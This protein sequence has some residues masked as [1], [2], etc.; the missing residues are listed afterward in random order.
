MAETK[1]NS[2]IHQTQF[3]LFPDQYGPNPENTLEQA[4]AAR[5]AA[6]AMLDTGRPALVLRAQAAILDMLESRLTISADDVF[7]RDPEIYEE[8]PNTVGAAFVGLG[9][10]GIIERI[11]YIPSKRKIR[12]GSAIG[13]W[14]KGPKWAEA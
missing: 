7:E 14:T 13:L 4:M 12:H 9:A 1:T 6:I 3:P 5:D 11:G 2:S 10:K 8:A